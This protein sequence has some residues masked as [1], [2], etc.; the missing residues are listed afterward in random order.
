VPFP[1]SDQTPLVAVPTPMQ[2]NFWYST[3]GGSFNYQQEAPAPGEQP[4]GDTINWSLML[5]Q[6]PF[7]GVDEF[8]T[9]PKVGE[10]QKE[11]VAPS[12]CNPPSSS[13]TEEPETMAV[14]GGFEFDSEMSPAEAYLQGLGGFPRYP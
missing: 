7:P 5:D 13:L 3:N 12:A 6:V 9:T 10:I 2:P 11:S 14:P 4:N 1:E 8:R